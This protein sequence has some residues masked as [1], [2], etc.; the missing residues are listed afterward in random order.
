MKIAILTPD[1]PS[2]EKSS[3]TFVHA[4]VKRYLES[5]IAVRIFVIA[6]EERHYRFED[7]EI[8]RCPRNRLQG[9]I[10]RYGPDVL[11]IHYPLARMISAVRSL[12]LPKIAWIHGHEIIW[13]SNLQPAK[14]LF[15]FFKKRLLLLPREL[16]QLCTIR[17]FLAEI[18]YCVFVSEWMHRIAEKHTLKKYS[19]YAVIPNPVDTE[20]FAYH[21]PGQIDKAVALRGFGNK[22][23]GIET[24][25]KAFSK[26]PESHIDIIGRGKFAEKYRRLAKKCG[27]NTNIIEQ[28]IDHDKVPELYRR[29][30]FFVAP[31]RAEAQGLAMCEAMACGLPVIASNVGGIPEFVRDGIDGYLVPPDNPHALTEAIKK[32]LSDANAFYRMSRNARAS[33]VERCDAKM[34]VQKE[35]ELFKKAKEIHNE[36]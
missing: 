4:R 28:S 16:F 29:Y 3:Y 13:Y 23:Y 24:A 36:S 27:S 18:E 10:S 14:N 26:L 12:D 31:S 32:L 25:V 22:K 21:K 35:L 9:E 8:Y 2:K 6:N 33:M 7:A 11:A 34:I 1:Y 19:N 5:G 17:N 15:D 30:S 20:L